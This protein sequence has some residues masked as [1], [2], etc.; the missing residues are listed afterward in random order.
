MYR[1]LFPL[2]I[3]AIYLPACAQPLA[4]SGYQ[5]ERQT[6][7][8]SGLV[9]PP[10]TL[11]LAVALQLAIAANADLSAARQEVAAVKA[12]VQQAGRSI[13]PTIEVE[14]EDTR[15]STRETT[16]QLSQPFE[17]GGKRAARVRAGGHRI[18]AASVE[19]ETKISEV[20]AA[21]TAAFF[22]V[23]AA[24]EGHALTNSSLEV[25]QR[26]TSIA[27]K[28]VSAGKA[29]PV[30]ETKARVAESG[31]RLESLKAESEL[32]L[33]RRRLAAL[34]GN[35][36]PSFS[37]AGGTL[38]GLP[39]QLK[40]STLTL[41]L[42][43]SPQVRRARIEVEHRS[44]LST[45]E[46]SRRIPDVAVKLGMKRSEELGRS[47]AIFGVSLPLPIFDRN[48]GNILESLRRTDKARDELAATMTRLDT[49]LA[50]AYERFSTARQE[51]QVLRQEILPGAKSGYDAAVTGFEFGKFSF[52]DVLDAQRTLL[53]SRTQ[54]LRALA[55]AHRATADI[56]AILGISL[57][58]NSR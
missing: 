46:R 51:A 45:V 8:P 56:D 33:S 6:P 39:E 31:V 1:Y 54:Y 21:V 16:I 57:H 15:R 28:R 20:R 52:L 47:Q 11:T 10:G 50:Q 48:Q 5:Y 44:A 14:V 17:L 35:P 27:S 9:E 36:A 2:S 18:D 41:R 32:R 29:S 40:L 37:N 3:A 55:D 49:E 43:D 7:S 30:E 23:V 34:W 26:G 24:Q 53:Q 12:G 4:Q 22:D 25:A 38:E 13:N 19:L 42:A 58:A